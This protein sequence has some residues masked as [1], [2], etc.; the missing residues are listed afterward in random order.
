MLFDG[1]LTFKSVYGFSGSGG[2]G[3]PREITPRAGDQFTLS[4]EWIEADEDGNVVTNVYEGDTLTFSG[5][6]FTV[7]AYDAY[8][9]DYVLSIMVS[10]LFGNETS[11]YAEVTVTEAE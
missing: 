2:T 1:E 11:E 7:A 8:A 10:D 3:A 9:G 6:P 5:Q 4:E